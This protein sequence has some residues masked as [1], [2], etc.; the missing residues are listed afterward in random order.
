MKKQE[1][2][3]TK[4]EE[5][6]EIRTHIQDDLRTRYTEF[7]NLFESFTG[8]KSKVL[9]HLVDMYHYRNGGYPNENSAPK[10]VELI[11]R[12]AWM[13]C[14]FSFV[15]LQNQYKVELAKYGISVTIQDGFKVQDSEVAPEALEVLL[16]QPELAIFMPDNRPRNLK[17]AIRAFIFACD[18][19][20]GEICAN[21]NTIKKEIAP[22]IE[23]NC[24]IN[25]GD[26][27]SSVMVNY[28]KTTDRVTKKKVE[29]LQKN[30]NSKVEVGSFNIKSATEV[31]P[32]E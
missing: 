23:Q 19:I 15:G 12:F 30:L 24:E 1:F 14:W 8:E 32:P 25:K 18:E 21:S 3:N 5:A 6:T 16:E 27:T 20:Q 17:Q 4:L 10:H 31:L 9:K 22:E 26:F 29:R 28:Q 13:V 11:E 7:K 2:F